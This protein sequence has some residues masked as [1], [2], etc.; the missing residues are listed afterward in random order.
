MWCVM[1]S[2]GIRVGECASM[3]W[4]DVD[5]ESAK[6]IVRGE[7][8]VRKNGRVITIGIPSMALRIL[9]AQYRVSCGQE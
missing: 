5:L 7:R 2:T 8:G 4:E 1:L 3:R 6:M 9:R